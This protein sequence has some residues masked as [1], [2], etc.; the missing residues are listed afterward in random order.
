LVE[1]YK[2]NDKVVF[3]AIGLDQWVD[4]KEFIKKL[5]FNYHLYTDGRDLAHNY[6]VNGY[7][8]NIVVDTAGKIAFQSKGGSIANTLWIRRAIDKALE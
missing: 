8:T 1:E 6:G 2:D 4:V 3:I 7:P 5:P